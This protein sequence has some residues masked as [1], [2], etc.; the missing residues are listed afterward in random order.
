LY[1]WEFEKNN[2][3]VNV[4]V[5]GQ[6]VFNSSAPILKA[7]LAGFGLA[8]IPE[9]MAQEHIQQGSLHRV[10]EDWCPSFQGYQIYF[11]SRRQ[12]SMAYS[13]LINALRYQS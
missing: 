7:A 6:L 3:T 1:A 9:D 12:S 5:Q 4:H 2:H 8:Y 13:L 10:L 11:A